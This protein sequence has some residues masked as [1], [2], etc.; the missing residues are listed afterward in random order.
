MTAPFQVGQAPGYYRFMLG[1]VEVTLL[2]D[3]AFT[4]PL[5]DDLVRN[6]T[7]AQV[8]DAL[9]AAFQ[10][11][12]TLTTP[13]TT[14]L[15]NTG[16]RLIM[17][18]AGSGE[19]GPP[20]TGHWMGNLQAAGYAPDD[21]DLIIVSHFHL[22]HIQGIRDAAGERLFPAAEIAVPEAE[23]AFWMDDERMKHAPEALR[24]S[25]EAARRVF[26]PVADEVIRFA[27]SDE[28]ASGIAP[29]EAPGH[30]PGH[31]AF[32]VASG[33]ERLLVWSD[34]TNKPELFVR[35][36]EWHGRFDADPVVAEATRRRLLELAA[37]ER[38]PVTGYHF[39]FPAL[40]FIA[41]RADAFEFV[42]AFW[43]TAA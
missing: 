31:T 6:A 11:R 3:G 1:E 21:V 7:T 42:P 16:E 15:L 26:G 27:G 25:F 35:H 34:T 4:R 2:S 18:D 13:F 40:G 43:R 29:V 8:R 5:A 41:R 39:P 12:D 19:M 24:P 30:T 9:G 22:D 33:G 32:I 10:P 20:G 36:P 38:M 17:I 28:I 37:H 14:T 23:W